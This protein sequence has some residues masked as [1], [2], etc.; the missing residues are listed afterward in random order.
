M[1][2]HLAGALIE[3]FLEVIAPLRHWYYN[4][5]EKSLNG[6]LPSSKFSIKAPA[7]CKT[8]VYVLMEIRHQ[9]SKRLGPY[10][11]YHILL[12]LQTVGLLS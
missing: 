5:N 7:K 2:L 4:Q 10:L 9:R 12:H 11:S 8:S 3:R 6:A 1:F